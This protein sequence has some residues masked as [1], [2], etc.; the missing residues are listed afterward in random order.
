MI[1]KLVGTLKIGRG[2]IISFH[3]KSATT[4]PSVADTDHYLKRSEYS[5]Y[6]HLPCS[7]RQ[8]GTCWFHLNNFGPSAN[9][10]A[11]YSKRS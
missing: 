1:F 10:I 6:S 2:Q 9:L 5:E 8:V 3:P 11:K 7:I 4:G